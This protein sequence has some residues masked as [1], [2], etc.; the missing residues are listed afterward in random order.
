VPGQGGNDELKS[1]WAEK[2]RMEYLR[3]IL[4]ACKP[5]PLNDSAAKATTAPEVGD[6]MDDGTIL[7]GNC[8]HAERCAGDLHI[9]RSRQIREESRRTRP[10]RFPRANQGR[11]ERAVLESHGH[12]WVR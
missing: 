3:E 6:E 11:V 4:E 5:D 1:G 12:R 7:A 9:Q 2:W 8:G 10:P